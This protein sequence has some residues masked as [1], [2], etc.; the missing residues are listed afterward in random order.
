MSVVTY[1]Q[2]D[3]L[4]WISCVT[5][6][7]H[8]MYQVV[9]V[10]LISSWSTAIKMNSCTNV[11]RC[12][13]FQK[14][15]QTKKAIIKKVTWSAFSQI[16]LHQM[17]FTKELPNIQ[18][19]KISA[20]TVQYVLNAMGFRVESFV[21]LFAKITTR[22]E[23]KIH[24]VFKLKNGKD[25]VMF[26]PFETWINF[27][28]MEKSIALCYKEGS[29]LLWNDDGLLFRLKVILYAPTRFVLP[30]RGTC[31]MKQW[32][33]NVISTKYLLRFCPIMY[34]RGD[35]M[36]FC[37]LIKSPSHAESKFVSEMC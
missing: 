12:N 27:K 19:S 11:M 7:D 22:T 30:A 14:N 28:I 5:S 3:Q 36:I 1:K 23:Q 25:K 8:L 33:K 17:Q 29:G 31:D 10:K 34:S 6:F 18:L 35:H 32:M 15:K 2:A 13:K 26:Q 4:Q 21:S 16:V 20:L 37:V 9:M 24:T